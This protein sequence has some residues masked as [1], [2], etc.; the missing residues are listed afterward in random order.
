[1]MLSKP[2]F[3]FV[4][5][6]SALEQAYGW[7]YSSPTATGACGNLDETGSAGDFSFTSIVNKSLFAAPGVPT[8]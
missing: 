7:T 4:F 6:L 1:M 8:S 3:L 2:I 5:I